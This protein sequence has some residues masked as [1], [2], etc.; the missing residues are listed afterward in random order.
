[1]YLCVSVF[2]HCFCQL[3]SA[4]RLPPLP[5]LSSPPGANYLLVAFK[6]AKDSSIWKWS[7]VQGL[8][9][10]QRKEGIRPFGCKMGNLEPSH[11][12]SFFHSACLWIFI[13]HI[14]HS[15]CCSSDT[16]GHAGSHIFIDLAPCLQRAVCFWEKPFFG[17]LFP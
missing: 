12:E 10:V 14:V 1:M 11:R 9:S 2:I 3:P 8:W 15:R 13:F 4:V 16:P 17:D 6:L 7:S 5:L